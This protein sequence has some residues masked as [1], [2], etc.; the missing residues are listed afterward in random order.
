VK[1]VLALV[2]IAFM[3]V[4]AATASYHNGHD[5]AVRDLPAGCRPTAGGVR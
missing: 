3:I 4:A 2:I 5:D 1:S